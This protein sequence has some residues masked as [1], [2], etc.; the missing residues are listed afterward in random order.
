MQPT[1]STVEELIMVIDAMDATAERVALKGGAYL[2][3]SFVLE[4]PSQDD[5]CSLSGMPACHCYT[6][7][8]RTTARD[9]VETRLDRLTFIARGPAR[10]PTH[11]E[12]LLFAG[13]GAEVCTV[14]SKGSPI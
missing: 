5:I 14:T 12:R 11:D 3:G 2:R 13:Q 9:V 8:G 7:I 1:Y 4:V 10:R 6:E